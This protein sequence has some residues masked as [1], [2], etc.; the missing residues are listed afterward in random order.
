[1]KKKAITLLLSIALASGSIGNVQVLAADTTGQEAESVQEESYEQEEEPDQ[2]EGPA[3]EADMEN[4]AEEVSE[5]EEAEFV[6]ED[7]D[8]ETE[9]VADKARNNGCYHA[10][11]VYFLIDCLVYDE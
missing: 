6:Q 5:T 7:E 4:A 3:E 11:P 9:E 8:S 10:D 1:M 2:E